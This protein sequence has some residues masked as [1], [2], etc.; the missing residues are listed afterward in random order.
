MLR[1]DAELFVDVD[2]HFLSTFSSE[3]ILNALKSVPAMP[4]PRPTADAH[5]E[6]VRLRGQFAIEHL[7]RQ[8]RNQGNELYKR[9]LSL[10]GEAQAKAFEAAEDKYMAALCGSEEDA[11]TNANLAALNLAMKA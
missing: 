4:S 11:V 10:K 3:A 1:E 9:G 2:S 7:A 8:M 6:H 5:L